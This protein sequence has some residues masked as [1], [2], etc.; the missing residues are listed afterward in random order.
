LVDGATFRLDSGS[1]FAGKSRAQILK[2]A[3]NAIVRDAAAHVIGSFL[4]A[5]ADE[6]AALDARSCVNLIGDLL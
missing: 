4:E 6:I 1:P 5:E 2:G 3:G